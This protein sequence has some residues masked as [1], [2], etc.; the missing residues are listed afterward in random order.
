MVHSRVRRR[1]WIG[2]NLRFPSGS[3]ALRRDRSHIC[4][5]SRLAMANEDRTSTAT[6]RAPTE[7]PLFRVTHCDKRTPAELDWCHVEMPFPTKLEG[8]NETSC[9]GHHTLRI[10]SQR[11]VG[12]RP[13]LQDEGNEG[14]AYRRSARQLREAMRDRCVF[15]LR[16]GGR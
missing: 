5:R 3:L 12:R 6:I 4:R 15:G 2:L 11:N 9:A 16:A 14:E 7:P 13:D 10:D 1:V 8:S